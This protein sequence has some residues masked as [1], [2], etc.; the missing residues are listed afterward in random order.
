MIVDE[1]HVADAAFDEAKNDAPVCAYRHR[2]IYI[3][4]VERREPIAKPLVDSP[5]A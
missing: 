2:P 5:R 1:I 3:V 4:I